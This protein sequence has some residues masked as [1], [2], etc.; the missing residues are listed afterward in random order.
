MKTLILSLA[1]LLC[2]C[3]CNKV[4]DS[5]VDKAISKAVTT[6]AQ[7]NKT[8]QYTIPKGA[9]YCDQ[10]GYRPVVTTQMTFTVKF[11]STAI[12]QT[13]QP[14]NQYDINKLYGFSDNNAD[15]HQYS[16]RIGW[17]WSDH[18]LHLFAYVYNAGTVASKELAT[19]LIG[20]EIKCSIQVAGSKYLFT[21]NGVTESMPR[22]STTPVGKGYQ[23]FPYFGG[24][25]TAPH[26]IHIYIKEEKL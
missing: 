17:R 10:N 23:L 22:A 2:L 15:H 20:S 4:V 13:V 24:N 1:A 3:S 12:Y 18:A 9:Q 6:K 14:V 11:D 21:V 25:E 19:V 5:V 7:Y 8:I 26:A 16:A